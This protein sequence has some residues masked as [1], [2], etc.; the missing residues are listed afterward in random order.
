MYFYKG[1][2]GIIFGMLMTTAD[3]YPTKTDTPLD[4]EALDVIRV[5][6][7]GAVRLLS[8]GVFLD[9]IGFYALCA[10]PY[11]LNA[12][13]SLYPHLLEI[14]KPDFFGLVLRMGNI[15]PCLGTFSTYITPS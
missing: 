1:E 13:C 12:L 10:D 8:G 3:N 4:H 9:L 11:A 15:M 5:S 2:Y 14:W 6:W 7:K